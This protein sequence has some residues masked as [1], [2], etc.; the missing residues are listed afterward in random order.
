M[1]TRINPTKQLLF[2]ALGLFFSV[3]PVGVAIFSYFPLWIRREDASIL[4]GISLLLLAAAI[5]PCYRYVKSALRSA[6]AP[7]MWFLFFM[8]FLLLSKIA[9][10]IT[11]ISFVGFISN[12]IGSVFFKLG[13]KGI[14]EGRI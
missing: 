9:D 7:M 3:I 10:E 13:R 6:S 14:D 1:D 2:N 11:V 8:I 4:S 12:L 5:V